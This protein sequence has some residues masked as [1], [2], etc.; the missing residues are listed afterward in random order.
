[1]FY[2]R[3]ET[4]Y[5][6]TIMLLCMYSTSHLVLLV[7]QVPDIPVHRFKYIVQLLTV[8]TSADIIIGFSAVSQ[9]M[10]LLVPVLY[11]LSALHET[12]SRADHQIVGQP[13]KLYIPCK[14]VKKNFSYLSISIHC[15][16]YC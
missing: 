11:Q 15:V 7:Y 6:Y 8:L 1:M 13:G 9:Y 3:G 5:W 16:C 12:K 4:G 2:I 14:I 10:Y